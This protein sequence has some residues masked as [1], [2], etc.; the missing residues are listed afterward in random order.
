MGIWTGCEEHLLD[1]DFFG[2]SCTR[3]PREVVPVSPALGEEELVPS[4]LLQFSKLNGTAA[5]Q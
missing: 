2:T 3:V 1:R 4:F 5:P